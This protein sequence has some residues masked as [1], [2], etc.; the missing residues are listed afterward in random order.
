M[1]GV[2]LDP[3]LLALPRDGRDIDHFL[4]RTLEW[5]DALK[6]AHL[7]FFISECYG[8]ALMECQALPKPHVIQQELNVHGIRAYDG[9]T[10]YGHLVGLLNKA[11]S[12]ESHARIS[13]RDFI[14][15][16]DLLTTVPEWVT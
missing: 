4:R 8:A 3:Y 16:E 12:I 10:I 1:T 9:P 5:A 13:A 11:Q 15:T 6:E 7:P 14:V 2:L